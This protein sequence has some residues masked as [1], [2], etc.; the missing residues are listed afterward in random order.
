[1][2]KKKDADA[3]GTH[4]HTYTALFIFPPL[5]PR[6]KRRLVYINPKL[7][8][9][10]LFSFPFSNSLII[11]FNMST[12]DNL[13]LDLTHLSF[14]TQTD[15]LATTTHASSL[16]SSSTAPSSSSRP[17]SRGLPS[18]TITQG[19]LQGKKIY[20]FFDSPHTPIPFVGAPS[21]VIQSW[22]LHGNLIYMFL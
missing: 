3:G 21:F 4:T 11:S 15:L 13:A 14:D 8:S 6:K 5:S 20:P 2:N 22:F 17:V 16:L 9:L 19:E 18:I 10:F 1:M 12:V 7:D